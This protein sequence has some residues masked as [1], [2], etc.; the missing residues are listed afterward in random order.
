MTETELR[1]RLRAIDPDPDSAA[2][3]RAWDVVRSAHRP[4]PT[5]PTRQRRLRWRLTVP[6]LASMLALAAIAVAVSNPPHVALARWLREAIGLNPAPHARPMLAG[7]P[8][9]GQLL[10]NSPAGPWLVNA[11]GHRRYLGHYTAAAWSPHSLYVVTWRGRELDALSPRGQRQWV[12]ASS[13]AIFVAR[14]SPDGYRIA[15]TA[16]HTLWVI[17]GDRTGNHRL[18]AADPAVAPAWQPRSGLAHRIAFV[19]P[20]GY[21]RLLDADS[22]AQLWRLKAQSA[23]RQLLWSADGTRLLV[24]SPTRAE[25]YSAGGQLLAATALAAGQTITQAAVAPDGHRVALAIHQ[26]GIAGNSIAV[27]TASRRGLGMPPQILF[28][29][30]AQIDGINWSPDD[31]W[32]LASSPSADQWIFIRTQPPVR[33]QSVSHIAAQFASHPGA[34]PGFPSLGGW[35]SAPPALR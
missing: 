32:L 25:L 14:W 17:A 26:P 35:Q 20:S 2:Q 29:A 10:V 6:A 7:L 3:E 9:G 34:A 24:L 11:S 8:G 23:V 27:L 21:V 31:L 18:A 1:D 30:R 28:S 13:G 22:G 16:G 19:D 4:A 5:P 15:Y 12:L 33:L